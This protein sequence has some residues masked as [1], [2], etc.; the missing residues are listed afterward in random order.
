VKIGIVMLRHPPTRKSPIMPEVIRLLRE[1]GATVDLIYPEE[2][3]A[4]LKKV[5]VKHDFYVIKSG[6]DLSLSLAGAL[7][8]SN[9]ITL[10]PY[11]VTLM[12]RNKIFATHRLRIAGVPIPETYV[13]SRV[14]QLAPL[15]EKGPLIIKPFTHC[16]GQG[17]HIVWDHD[18]L[19]R[20]SPNQGPIFAQRYYSP[21]GKD[22]KIY[23]IDGQIFGVKRIWPAR[24]YE[25]KVGKPFTISSTLRQIAL[26][27]SRAFGIELLGFDVI[28]SGGRPYVVDINCFPGFKGVPNAALR[29]ADFIYTYGQRVLDGKVMRQD[30]KKVMLS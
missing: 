29:L 21:Q 18:G 1:W 22:H 6:T 12:M 7:H 16:N 10:N 25:E 3:L 2:Q 17:V 8:A 27:C 24:T 15:L 19:S 13:T 14:E 5:Q 4:D 9:A 20:I 30:F 28:F 23:Y 26:R 11:P